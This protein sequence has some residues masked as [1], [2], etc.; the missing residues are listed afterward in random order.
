MSDNIYPLDQATIARR[1]AEDEADKAR[2][3]AWVSRP[4]YY[5]GKGQRPAA[6][7]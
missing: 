4:T 2:H 1:H 3:D 7:I 6:G 5:W